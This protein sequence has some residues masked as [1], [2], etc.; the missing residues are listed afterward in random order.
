MSEMNR[1]EF[2]KAAMA[3]AAACACIGCPL[4]GEVLAAPPTGGKDRAGGG[5][6]PG[7]TGGK[8]D[9]GS[10]ADYPTENTISEKFLKTNKLAVIRS[11]GKIYATSAVCTH[12]FALLNVKG[13]EFACPKHGSKFSINGTPT[14]GPASNSLVRYEITKNDAGHV[15]VNTAKSF[16]EKD[17]SDP[18]SFVA[19]S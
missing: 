19:V 9:I 13:Q 11:D 8:V 12:K 10:I 5:S 6:A 2:V 17:W 18:T 3:A 7:A 14:H 15:I 4:S 16:R 1:R